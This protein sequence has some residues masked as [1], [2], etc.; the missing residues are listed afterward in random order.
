MAH[1]PPYETD[2]L[3]WVAV[4]VR[5]PLLEGLEDGVPAGLRERLHAD[6]PIVEEQSELAVSFGVGSPTTQQAR[7]FRF[8]TRDRLRSVLIGRD[9]VAVETTTYGGWTT[10]FRGQVVEILRAVADTLTPDGVVRV[11]LRYI[12]EVRVPEQVDDVA[13]WAPW[14]DERLVAPFSLDPTMQPT[15]ATIALQFGEPPGYVTVFRAAPF[16]AG[17]TVQSEGPLRMP[18]ETPDGPYFLLDTDAAWTDPRREVPEFD[19]DAI[20][21]VLDHLHEPCHR[22][23]EGSITERLRSEVLRRPTEEVFGL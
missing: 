6:F 17:R 10:D 14:I 20:R 5:Y 23:F 4:E 9:A 2:A 19:P 16:A 11:G 3:R 22:L 7:R 18:Y 8:L 12:D 21:D 1:T 13:G 15:S